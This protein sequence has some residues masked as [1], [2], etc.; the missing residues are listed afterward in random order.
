VQFPSIT[1]TL[2]GRLDIP[3]YNPYI[4]LP[5]PALSYRL[6]T[7]QRT[8]C[9]AQIV[10]P[11]FTMDFLFASI[12]FVS[13][14]YLVFLGRISLSQRPEKKNL[15]IPLS[16]FFVSS[17]F[18]FARRNLR[19]FLPASSFRTST[20]RPL[21]HSPS[22]LS[23][24]GSF[25]VNSA[26]TKNTRIWA[27][28]DAYLSRNFRSFAFSLPI[29]S[30]PFLF[31]SS[32][33]LASSFSFPSL[34][35]TPNIPLY[36][37]LLVLPLFFSSPFVFRIPEI[38]R[39]TCA[40]FSEGASPSIV[41]KS[42]YFSAAT[43]LLLCS[44]VPAPSLPLPISRPSFLRSVTFTRLFPPRIRPPFAFTPSCLLFFV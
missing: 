31:P 37:L 17:C 24:L 4:L 14:D 44:H 19:P 6:L 5:L 40:R 16:L 23:T 22:L 15:S 8:R 35:S 13:G 1:I 21:F 9:P 27:S 32:S 29:I 3:D 41:M 7:L 11:T 2:H 42:D 10:S 26:I 28:S 25:I 34:Q 33:S 36:L 18:R 43:L 30:S 39:R 12:I 20:I 38:E